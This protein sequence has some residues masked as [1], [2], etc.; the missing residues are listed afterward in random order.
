MALLS[1]VF[2]FGHFLWIFNLPQRQFY[3]NLELLAHYRVHSVISDGTA[4]KM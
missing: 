1:E 2:Q 3:F 4:E